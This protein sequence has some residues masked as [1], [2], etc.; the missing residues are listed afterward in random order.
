MPLIFFSV[1][2]HMG[3]VMGN[4]CPAVG[5]RLWLKAKT[6]SA[7]SDLCDVAAAF[8]TYL[9]PSTG[10]RSTSGI[11]GCGRI[12][13][14]TSSAD[15]LH[16][17]CFNNNN[18]KVLITT[19]LTTNSNSRS[20][21]IA[22]VFLLLS[23]FSALLLTCVW[24]LPGRRGECWPGHMCMR[25]GVRDMWAACGNDFLLPVDPLQP[26]PEGNKENRELN[27]DQLIS[28]FS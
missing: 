28:M 26:T 25:V 6:H 16:I 21:Q 3:L 12:W 20:K 4:I 2:S 14:E 19:D 15:E 18:N 22:F 24:S 11:R 13:R 10:R 23:P 7:D 5:Q 9:G 17:C 8:L 27:L 1:K